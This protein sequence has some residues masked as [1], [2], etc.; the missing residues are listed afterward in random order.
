ME[1]LA[2][3]PYI[4]VTRE[5]EFNQQCYREE[6]QELVLYENVVVSNSHTFSLPDIFDVSYKKL[7]EHDGFLYLHTNQGL[8][9]FY[10]KKNPSSFIKEYKKLK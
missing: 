7:S 10:T 4:K 9:S 8:F 2:T 6:E 5:I 3:Q 1:I